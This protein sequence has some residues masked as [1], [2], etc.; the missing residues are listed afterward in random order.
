M[1]IVNISFAV[2]DASSERVLDAFLPELANITGCTVVHTDVRKAT[3]SEQTE[4]DRI[5]NERT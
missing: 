1:H 3:E 4:F 5:Q 2:K